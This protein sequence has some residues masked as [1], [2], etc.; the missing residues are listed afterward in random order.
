[1]AP[2]AGVRASIVWSA[3]GVRIPVSVDFYDLGVGHDEVSLV[4]F[5]TEQPYPTS[6]EARLLSL[7]V[8]RALSQPQ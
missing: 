3:N 5:S 8:A 1:M 4:V 2:L 7:L 6:E